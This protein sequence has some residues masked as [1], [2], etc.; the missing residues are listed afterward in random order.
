MNSPSQKKS[1]V[2]AATRELTFGQAINEAL[3]DWLKK[4]K[5]VDIPSL[6]KIENEIS[7]EIKAAVNFALNAPFPPSQEVNQHVYA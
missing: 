7:T 3:A 4:N 5:L 2:E 1:S 6:E